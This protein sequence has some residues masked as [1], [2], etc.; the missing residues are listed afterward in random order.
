MKKKIISVLT[1]LAIIIGTVPLGIM[2]VFAASSGTA[3]ASTP[4][5]RSSVTKSGTFTL[6]SAAR[7]FIVSDADPTGSDL[8][9]Y[10]QTASSVLAAKNIPTS[11]PLTIVYGRESAAQ[12]GDIVIRT[13]SSATGHRGGYVLDISAGGISITADDAEGVLYALTTLAQT[14]TSG[15]VLKCTTVTDWPDVA[16]RSVYL[17]CGRIYFAPATLKALI[18]TMAWNRMNVLYLDFSN[19][20]ATRF[21]LDDM[22]VTVGG[23]TYD[24]TTAAPSDGYLTQSDMDDI[25]DE[26]NRYGVQIIPTFNSPGHIGGIRSVN[27]SFFRSASA[28]DYDSATGKVALNILDQTAY[29]F[30]QAVVKLYVDYFASKGCRSFNIAADEVT[31]AISGLNSSNST[32]VSYV[33]DLNTY[34]KSKGMTTRMFNDGYKSI[35]SGISRDIV[36]LYWT[37]E[38]VNAQTLIDAGHPVVNLN[39]HAGLY[40]AYCS[41]INSA[42][43][44]NQDVDKIYAGWNPGVTSCK[45]YHWSSSSYA[46]TPQEW[47]NDY[48][49][50]E[51]LLG[52]AFAIWTDFAFNRGKNGTT[53]F[54]ENYKNMMQKI[55]TVAERSWS[56]SCTDSYSTWSGKL[57]AAPGGLTMSG[58]VDGTALPAAKKITQAVGYGYEIGAF[59]VTA[60]RRTMTGITLSWTAPSA[61]KAVTYTVKKTVS[62][63]TTVLAENTTSLSLD[64]NDARSDA[65]Y[66][67]IASMTENG[68]DLAQPVSVSVTSAGG[69]LPVFVQGS[70]AAVSVGGDISYVLDTDG[71]EEGTYVMVIYNTNNESSSN[72]YAVS[73]SMKNSAPYGLVTTKVTQYVD[74]SAKTVD[75]SSLASDSY[76]WNITVSGGKYYITAANGNGTLS[77]NGQNNVSLSGSNTA[78]TLKTGSRTGAYYVNYSGTN[79]YRLDMYSDRSGY[80][81]SN[82]QCLLSAWDTSGSQNHNNVYFYRQTGSASDLYKADDSSLLELIAFA[83]GIDSSLYSNWDAL[84]VD[85]LIAAARAASS[86]SEYSVIADA[87]A[88][89]KAINDAGQALYD[90]LMKLGTEMIYYGTVTVKYV[91]DAGLVLRSETVMRGEEGTAYTIVPE[92]ISGYLTP[93]SVSGVYGRNTNEEITLV[94]TLSTDKTALK[95]ELDNAVEQGDYTDESYSAY[96]A[97]L[98]AAREVYNNSRAL[99]SEVDSALAAVVNAKANLKSALVVVSPKSIAA[100]SN[101]EFY[102]SYTGSLALDGSSSTYAWIAS[103]QRTGDW[104]RVAFDDVYTVSDVTVTS[105]YG[106]D[107]IRSA[108]IQVSVN[109]S[110]WTTVGTYSG[111]GTKTVSFGRFVDARYVRLCLTSSSDY[112]WVVNEI[113]FTFG[114]ESEY[115][116]QLPEMPVFRLDSDG[117]INSGSEYVIKSSGSDYALAVSG[118]TLTSVTVSPDDNAVSTDNDYAV[119]VITKSGSGYTIR[120][121]GSGQYL[122]ITASGNWFWSSE[123]TLSLS[124]SASVFYAEGSGTYSFYVYSGR[125]YYYLGLN[126]TVPTAT[127]GGYQISTEF[128]LYIADN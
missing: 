55:Y 101:R 113:S 62:G 54:A 8:G 1:V 93:S 108:D 48:K 74:T 103:A 99:Q 91:D 16:E 109:G 66:T 119:W 118:G 67:V 45:V 71:I 70:V 34:I 33:N 111:S 13:D 95:N 122:R 78:L 81:P 25:I 120:N 114:P 5:V 75:I 115:A 121:K 36:I 41:G 12:A 24:I 94:Y 14:C 37:T 102:Q 38:S 20:N 18:R 69:G 22:D 68:V 61:E 72:Y 89:Q 76:L 117:T 59:A 85:S 60:T 80:T 107:H 26:A 19:N 126:G 124:Q 27:T 84:S 35:S 11:S 77:I 51:K 2:P 128:L 123:A 90:A 47:V 116:G 64:D 96:T 21:L 28:S 17:D 100:S 79:G 110:D 40:Y 29:A 57:K 127:S 112:W 10:V 44:W 9:T 82:G 65:V 86:V 39:C 125:R 42:Y 6:T 46:Y 105:S 92:T 87:E 83:E 88:E 56:T 43:V 31:D 7:L 106:N 58:S 15:T 73:S 52:A 63:K 32:F 104:F 97:A 50:E 23:M 49:N 53:I 3:V 30:G 98:E 4:A